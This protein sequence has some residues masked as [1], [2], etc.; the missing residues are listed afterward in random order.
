MLSFNGYTNLSEARSRGEEM[1]EFIVA[2]VN[3]DKEPKS[4]YGIPSGA[5]KN[6]AKFLKS[7]GVKGKGNV[8]GASTINTSPEWASYWP[9][10]KVP[11]STKTPKTDFLI[12]NNKISL[13]SGKAAQLMSGGR[14]ESIATFY[15]ALKSVEGMQKKVVNRLTDM[16]EGLAPASVAGSEL[17]KEIKKGKDKVVLKADKAHKELMGDLKTIFSG[18]Q[19]FANAFAYEAMSGD[20]KF[21]K[22]SPGSCTHFLTTSFDGKKAHLAKVNDKSYVGK[23][24]KQMKVSVRFKSASEQRASL[25]TK[26]NPK[27]KTGRYKYWSAVGLI[28]DKLE[29]E[30]KP[31]EGQM[32]NEGILDKLKTIYGKVKDFIVNIFE[33]IMSYVSKGF[34]YLIDFLDLE[35]Q[36]DVDPTV[37]TDV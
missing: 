27:G 32:L 23:I 10:G 36:V 20:V 8:L 33:K 11:G 30:M 2:A 1:E 37:R 31:I 9:G 7:K 25:K 29:E 13:K 17:G 16:F 15:T 34:A 26:A 21:G 6:V 19:K 35:P 12:G 5:G 18:N 14:N 22:N 24:A 28:V 3:G 4:K